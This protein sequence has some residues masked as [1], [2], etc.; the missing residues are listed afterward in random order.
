[1]DCGVMCIHLSWCL[2]HKTTEHTGISFIAD[3][4]ATA[5]LCR[6]PALAVP[7]HKSRRQQESS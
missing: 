2:I 7:F 5:G 6:K 3:Q 1:M 4:S